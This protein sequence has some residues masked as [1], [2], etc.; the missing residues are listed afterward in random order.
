MEYPFGNNPAKIEGYKKFWKREPVPRPLVGLSIKSWFS[1]LEFSATRQWKPGTVLSP[2]M[3]RVDDFLDD[4]EQLLMEGQEMADDILRGA[5]PLQGLRWFPAFLGSTLT[6]LGESIS[7]R[8]RGLSWEEI[9]TMELDFQDPWFRKYIEFTEALVERSGGR[10]PVSHGTLLGPS[11]M[12]AVLRGH[13]QLAYDF[14]D[15]PEKVSSLLM[16][17]GTFFC[18]I[19]DE[20]RKHIPQFLGGY[21]DAQYQLW[22]PEPTIRLQEDNGFYF[23]PELYRTLLQPADHRMASRY[24]C[25][26]IHLH[27]TS[28]YLLEAFLEVKEIRAFEM[29]IEPF[30]IGLRD[31]IRYFQMVQEA[32]RPLLVRGSIKADELKLLLDELDPAGLYLYIMVQDLREAESCRKLLA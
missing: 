27:S 7:A 16:K 23:S 9:D 30:N 22:A 24:P 29:N 3:I 12:A 28:M 21:F 13:V 8:D 26:F 20:Q 14:Y 18:E 4:Q 1:I 6:I 17:M 25:S 19:L 31:M 32:D 5:C 11:D 2:D 15:Y 10:Y